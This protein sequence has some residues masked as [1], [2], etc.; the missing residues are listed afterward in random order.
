M[1]T[2]DIPCYFINLDTAVERRQAMEKA[3]QQSGFSHFQR[4]EAIRGSQ[5]SKDQLEQCTTLMTRA[6]LKLKTRRAFEDMDS[7]A[8]VGVSLSHFSLYRHCLS[9]HPNAKQFM[10]FEDDCLFDTFLQQKGLLCQTIDRELQQLQQRAPHWD[11]F[12]LGYMFLRDRVPLGTR[13]QI[14]QV[15]KSPLSIQM[16]YTDQYAEVR[17]FCGTNAYVIKRSVMEKMLDQ[18]AFPIETHLDAWMGMLSQ[19]GEICLVAS[20]TLCISQPVWGEINH[21]WMHLGIL[22]ENDFWYKIVVWVFLFLFLLF[23]LYRFVL[24]KFFFSSSSS[25]SDNGPLSTKPLWK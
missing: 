13:P 17:S 2:K 24:R 6:K 22:N 7:L 5:L 9:K 25:F 18:W 12:L 16:M 3:S 21:G 15:L 1:K 4:F 14:S 20:P 10:I 8:A 23:L 19:T 11:V